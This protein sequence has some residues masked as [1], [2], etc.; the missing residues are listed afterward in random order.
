MDYK[1]KVGVCKMKNIPKI[2]DSE[3]QIMKVLWEKSPQTSSEIIKALENETDWKP[4]TIQTLITRLVNKGA[5]TFEKENRT[6]LYNWSVS[7]DECIK[8]ESESFLKR[9]YKG[10]FG[11]MMVNFLQDHKLSVEEI[12]KLKNILNDDKDRG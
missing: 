10:S 1:C 6:H 3:W 9:V 5:V 7:E 11:L 8:Y 12:E 2:S 4:K